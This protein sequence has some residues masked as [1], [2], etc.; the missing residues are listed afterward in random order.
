MQA[1]DHVPPM[2]SAAEAPS[3]FRL[4]DEPGSHPQVGVY[5]GE[6]RASSHD[7]VEQFS[8]FQPQLEVMMT[9][10]RFDLLGVLAL[11]AVALTIVGCERGTGTE[12]EPSSAEAGHPNILLIVADDMGYSDIGSFGGEIATPALDGLADE[13]LRLSNMVVV[14]VLLKQ[15]GSP[16]ETQPVDH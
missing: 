14:P 5:S 1:A 8:R 4:L 3:A 13:G 15:F 9:G 6:F 12:G 11:L 16:V 7:S 10:R 2:M